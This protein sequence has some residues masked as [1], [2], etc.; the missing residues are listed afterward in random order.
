[1]VTP[2]IDE[3][4][5][6]RRRGRDARPAGCRSRATR[7]SSSPG[8]PARRPTL[9]DAE[10]LDA[11]GGGRRGGDHP[12]GRR[13]RHQRHRPLGPPHRRGVQAR[14]RRHPRPLPVLQPAR[15]RP[16]SRRHLRAVAE[17]TDLPVI[18][19]DIPVRTGRKVATRRC[20][21][22]SPTR[23]HNIV[24]R[25]GRRRQPGR[26]RPPGRRRS[27]R[28]RGATAATTRLTLPLLAVGAVGVD[29]RGHPLGGPERRRAVRPRP[30]PATPAALARQ[31]PPARR[32]GR[33]RP[34]TTCPNPGPGQGDAAPPR[35]A[36]RSTAARRWDADPPWLADA[37]AEVSPNLLAAAWPDR[38]LRPS[39]SSGG[40]GEIGRNC[41][42][43]EQGD[44]DDRR[45]CSSTAG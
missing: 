11:V 5:L 25:Q 43:L 40:L 34:V 39:S 10:K 19:Y 24:G 32:A 3:R 33:T 14:R 6:D 8:P 4:P 45:S 23:S 28:L 21:P 9:T 2:F 18:I 20:S 31:R 41:M 35:P 42:A 30:A 26:D 15:R 22:A 29:R 12:G 37:A 1:M 16:A 36:C 13:L 7:A 17:A 27:R 44:G 38:R